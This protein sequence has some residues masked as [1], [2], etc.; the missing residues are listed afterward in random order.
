MKKTALIN[1]I[2]LREAWQRV[3]VPWQGNT[4]GEVVE[5]FLKCL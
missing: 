4:P 1:T 3:A 2:E 5:M